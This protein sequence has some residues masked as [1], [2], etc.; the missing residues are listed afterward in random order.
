MC[1]HRKTIKR[2]G[3]SNDRPPAERYWIL[4]CV[5]CG[6]VIRSET[7]VLELRRPSLSDLLG[8]IDNTGDPE[9]Y[10]RA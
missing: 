6:H 9:W 8:R 7:Q 2:N 3:C 1:Q 10:R 4:A 5:S